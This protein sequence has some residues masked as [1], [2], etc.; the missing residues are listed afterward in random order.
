MRIPTSPSLVFAVSLLAASFGCDDGGSLAPDMAVPDSGSPVGRDMRTEAGPAD[1]G[2]AFAPD[3]D[4]NP[5]QLN[6]VAAPGMASMAGRLTISNQGNADLEI[7]GVMF[8]DESADFTVMYDDAPWPDG[9]SL[10]LGQ[11]E[12]AELQVVFAPQGEGDRTATLL[13]ESNDPDELRREVVING[14]NPESCIRAMPGSVNLGS[15][16]VGGETARFAVQVVNCG[17]QPANIGEIALDGDAGFSWE[18]SQGMG[19]GQVL[20]PGSVLIL[21]VWY[22]NAA[23]G[24]DETSTTVLVVPTDLPV[25]DLRVNVLVR[26]GGGPTCAMVIEPAMVDYETLRLGATRPVELTVANRGTAHCEVRSLAVQA[27]DGPEENGFVIVRGIEGDRFEGG[28][29]QTIEVAYA[30]VVADPIGDRAELRL[31]FHDPHRVQNRTATAMLRGVGSEALIGADPPAV[32]TGVTTVGCV[33]WRRS[34][35]VGNVGFV[36]IC[37]SGFRYEGEGCDRFVPVTEPSIPEG[38][39]IA[40]QR[41]EVVTFSF[42]HQPGGVDAESCTLIVESDAQNTGAIEVPLRGDGTDTAETTDAAEVGDLNGRRDAFFPLSR[43]CDDETLR[44]FVNDAESQRFGF[45]AQR[46]ALVFEANRH[47]ADEGDIIRMQYEA[48]CFQLDD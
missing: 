16:A 17:D 44:L 22:D 14:R 12:A 35:D 11:D 21:E 8:A 38:E 34:V 18:V 41:N 47:P 3:I 13:I 26:G 40:L 24:A 42:Q 6:L 28:A 31:G 5:G 10:V 33:S 7:T 4:I 23:L 2:P 15:V 39:C 32:D 48:R 1:S 9:G 20:R 25:G 27:T 36:P 29:E 37:V 45:S 46:N 19:S 30:P 43:P